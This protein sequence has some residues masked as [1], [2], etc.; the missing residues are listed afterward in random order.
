[1]LLSK[2]RLAPTLSFGCLLLVNLIF[3]AACGGGGGGGGGVIIVA[4]SGA[5]VDVTGTWTENCVYD[6]NNDQAHKK[7]Y[8]FSGNTITFSEA[9]WF[10]NTN[11]AGSP[12]RVVGG[13]RTVSIGSTVN[14]TWIHSG[15]GS[16]AP[17]A[18][19]PSPVLANQ[20]LLSWA[21][22]LSGKETWV[23]DDSSTTL[24]FYMGWIDL[25]NPGIPPD[26]DAE[27]YPTEVYSNMP[28][29]R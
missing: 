23:V 1:M 26:I 24:D 15:T 13:P 29:S 17:P 12:D 22:G 18:G 6:P 16:T 2:I 14:A 9:T 5:S 8:T 27:G 7:T 3:L 28:V 19:L 11:C 20:V 4:T 25:E 10:G 21:P